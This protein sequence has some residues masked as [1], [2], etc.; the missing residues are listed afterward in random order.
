MQKTG[1]ILMLLA[2]QCIWSQEKFS[3]FFESNQHQLNLKETERLNQ[4]LNQNKESKILS[5]N[6][7]TDEDGSVEYN[8]T[9]SMKRVNTVFELIQNKIA[10][11]EDFKKEHFGKLHE[12]SKNKAENRRVTL[13]YLTKENLSQEDILIPK[14]KTEEKKIEKINFPKQIFIANPDGSETEMNLDVAFMESI[15]EAKAGDKILMKDLNFVVNTFAVVNE[16]RPRM[17]ELLMVMQ[18]IPSLKIEIEGHICCTPKDRTDLSSQRAKAIKNFLIHFGI[19][20]SRV[21]YKGYG[22]TQ[23]KFPIP[24]K[25]EDEKAANRRVEINIVDK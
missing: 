7:F 13:F 17:F 14:P 11:R 10:I 23:P 12:Q 1:F 20:G 3:L 9:L 4:F 19:D 22:S 15:S 24:E 6:G 21:S 2:F 16:S 5:I 18:Q 25:N 8:D